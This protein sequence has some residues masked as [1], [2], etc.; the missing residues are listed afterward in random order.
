MTYYKLSLSSI[1]HKRMNNH[2]INGQ[3]LPVF[4]GIKLIKG[5][6]VQMPNS[7]GK[8]LNCK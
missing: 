5:G 6:K 3:S 2:N 7:Q 4:F 1:K 8:K